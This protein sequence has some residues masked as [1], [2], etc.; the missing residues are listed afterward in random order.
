MTQAK[1]KKFLAAID[2]PASHFPSG[3]NLVRM[4]G[5]WS[6]RK[7][8]SPLEVLGVMIFAGIYR[9]VFG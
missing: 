5:R 4:V 2:D 9:A 1:W 6:I 8:W 3:G 7:R